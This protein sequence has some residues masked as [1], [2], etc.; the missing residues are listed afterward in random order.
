MGG[1]NEYSVTIVLYLRCKKQVHLYQAVDA[2]LSAAF[3]GSK[4]NSKEW[5]GLYKSVV[6]FHLPCEHYDPDFMNSATG[7][8]CGLG[9]EPGRGGGTAENDQLLKMKR[10]TDKEWE[11]ANQDIKKKVG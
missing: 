3:E 1:A 4:F 9:E 6:T 10:V 7:K 11:S 2:K 8:L 5:N